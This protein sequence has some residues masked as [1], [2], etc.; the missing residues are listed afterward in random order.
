MN[1]P[2]P[3]GVRGLAVMNQRELPVADTTRVKRSFLWMS[4]LQLVVA[5]FLHCCSHE[6]GFEAF[7]P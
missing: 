6:K 7:S 4:G 2:A 1:G 5:I 3:V